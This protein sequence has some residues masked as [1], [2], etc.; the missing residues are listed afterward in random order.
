M[1]P[2]QLYSD[3]D[4]APIA[5]RYAQ[6]TRRR[7]W[8]SANHRASQEVQRR[9]AAEAP[10]LWRPAVRTLRQAATALVA[11][12]TPP[13]RRL[14]ASQQA[15]LVDV[16]VQRG[17]Q[18]GRL[19]R[20]EGL[21][22]G[23]AVRRLALRVIRD[24]RREGVAPQF[25]KSRLESTEGDA[26]EAL[27]WL[28]RAYCDE[29]HK[30]QLTDDAGLFTL[31]TQSLR[32]SRADARFERLVLHTSAKQPDPPETEL[33]QAL[34]AASESVVILA[35]P[36]L[37]RGDDEAATAWRLSLTETLGA[38]VEVSPGTV[39]KRSGPVVLSRIRTDLFAGDAAPVKHDN[40]DH[41][42]VLAAS[43]E[44]DEARR[45]VARVKTWLLE[46]QTP[47]TDIVIAAPSADY[48]E[49]LR[50]EL[51]AAGVPAT[52][53]SAAPLSR[54]SWWRA[55]RA[56]LAVD[57][58]DWAYDDLLAL[59]GRTDLAALTRR[60]E[61][62]PV[63]TTVE[64]FIRKT[65]AP[66]GRRYL[67]ERAA[68]TADPAAEG[69]GVLAAAIDKLPPQAEP[70]A[71]FDALLAASETL[72]WRAI[73]ENGEFE[74]SAKGAIERALSETE[75]LHAW[76]GSKR[77]LWSRTE[78]ARWLVSASG[79]ISVGPTPAI[80]PAVRVV[81][82]DTAATL[83]VQRLAVVGLS[84][85]SFS[86]GIG[87][88]TDVRAAADLATLRFHALVG[89]PE[90]S[91]LLSFPALDSKA[92]TLRPS[93]LVSD[94]ERLFP[95]DSLRKDQQQLQAVDRRYAPATSRSLRLAAVAGAAEGDSAPLAA[96]FSFGENAAS[97]LL[98][99][100]RT[101]RVRARGEGFG[102]FEASTH[103]AADLLERLFGPEHPWSASQLERYATCPFQFFAHDAIRAEPV[104]DLRLAID[105]RHR[106]SRVHQLLADLH[107]TIESG[108][109]TSSEVAEAIDRAFVT[110]SQEGA[111]PEHQ[112]A[113]AAI[114]RLQLERWLAGHPEQT[115]RYALEWRGL[116]TPI[117]PALFE[118]R[119]GKA[120]R[121][122]AGVDKHSTE[123]PL[124]L[125]APD[126]GPIKIEGTIDRVDV[127]EHAGTPVFSVIDYK[128]SKNL[129]VKETDT[130]AGTHL[131]PLLYAMAVRQLFLTATG[132]E[133][134][135]L[136]AG[137]WG[138]RSNK[139]A[140]PI[141]GLVRWTDNTAEPTEVWAETES[142]VIERIGAIVRGALQGEFSV[143]PIDKKACEYCDYKRVCRVSQARAVGKLP[144]VDGEEQ[145]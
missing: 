106:G 16:V 142:R 71:W 3:Q 19:D 62:E 40:T 92:Q 130:H 48:Y 108:T 2:V 14:S 58:S 144:D 24:L 7:L 87:S 103:A 34:V 11:D 65:Q 27:A 55:L 54:S 68:R 38:Q 74:Q 30:H 86:A 59:V 113:L 139:L 120:R 51:E 119:F 28:Y 93:P 66:S 77:P 95:R 45:V 134:L 9:L 116:D 128:T 36:T 126:V 137:Y 43:G 131:Q 89:R 132:K 99:A 4:L 97:S 15:A 125:E 105:Q 84:E 98:G 107:A 82:Y 44:Q 56:V 141:E 140:E 67:L 104:E 21:T 90:K 57:A 111:L 138:V 79:W 110:V 47:P 53:D 69:L 46:Q 72:C 31:A 91:L 10:A 122:D 115:E 85:S 17:Q 33:L 50:R 78:I 60:V 76:R 12:T 37:V 96:F 1:P 83:S 29:V 100:V 73:D 117:E 8:I 49:R 20:L 145:P 112:R 61:G 136:F 133:A 94:V 129:S 35:P 124:Q 42:E 127:G 81:G 25:A 13:V 75:T 101:T 6:A 135:P 64:R 22:R 70:L 123:Q 41:V 26:G 114:E 18:S 102:P 88:N 52:Y 80:E 121:D 23:D 5:G 32:S 118:A 39:A 109:A 63:A 143:K